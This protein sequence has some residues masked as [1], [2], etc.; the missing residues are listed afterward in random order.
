MSGGSAGR[1]L[2]TLAHLRPGQLAAQLRTKALPGWNDPSW[3][4]SHTVPAT[5]EIVW[6]PVAAW[7][8][9]DPQANTADALLAGRFTF[10]NDTRE[11]GWPPEYAADAPLLWKYNLHYLEW[12][13][14]LDHGAAVDAALE[15]IRRNPPVIQ[16]VGWE[17]YPTSLRLQTLCLIAAAQPEAIPRLWPSIWQQAEHLSRRLEYHLLGNHLLENAIALAFVGSCFAGSAARRWHAT[18]LRLLGEQLPEQVLSDGG[19][20]ERSPMYQTRLTYALALLANTGD[21]SLIAAVAKPLAAMTTALVSLCHP[22]GEIALFNDSA[23]GIYH[24][25]AK[26]IAFAAAALGASPPTARESLPDA[27]YY[28]GTNPRGDTVLCDAGLL[29]PDYLPGHAHGDMFSFELSLGGRR[30]IVDSGTFDYVPSDMRAYCRSTAAH[31][32]VTIDDEDQAEF[33]GAF[34][35]GRRGRP[36]DVAYS[37]KTGG[38]TLEGWHDGYRHLPSRAIH[39]RRFEWSDT[40]ALRIVDRVTATRPVRAAARLHLHPEVRLIGSVE[41]DMRFTCGD[42]GFSVTFSG[43]GRV[44]R[45]DGWYCPRFGVR[46]RNTVLVSEAIGKESE[47]NCVIERTDHGA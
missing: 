42:V 2:R 41:N 13:W 7:L 36:H 3:V 29:G 27:G 6:Q 14:A 1:L 28:R 38:F 8:A 15:W 44:R 18:G 16:A 31:N 40:G 47:I 35:V 11:I 37:P 9:P 17:P 10:I 45:E 26:V 30:V 23:V 22:D 43:I 24:H 39:R 34:R 33:W 19:H 25:P 21:A 12:L 32:T 4:R 46:E 20:F 5:P